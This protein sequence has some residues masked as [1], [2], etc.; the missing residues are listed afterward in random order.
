MMLCLSWQKLF[1]LLR[2][3]T[4]RLITVL[5]LQCTQ[6]TDHLFCLHCTQEIDELYKIF[7]LLGTP[8]EH[9]WPGVS[10]LPDYKD[11]FP[12]WRPQPLA[13]IVPSLDPVGLD[14]LSKM[15][16]Y[17]PQAR[18]TARAALGHQYFHDIQ[19]IL[20]QQQ[21]LIPH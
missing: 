8:N 15:L 1:A 17:D 21:R 12:S 5:C 4:E 10:H 14:L 11:T 13:D 19:P 6:G 9:I 18:I 3:Y 20:H 16:V 2:M 7:M